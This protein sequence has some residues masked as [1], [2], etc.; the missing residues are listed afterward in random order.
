[1][2]VNEERI[3]Y[4]IE[5]HRLAVWSLNEL[6]MPHNLRGI[7]SDAIGVVE[8]P[9]FSFILARILGRARS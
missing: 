2:M 6:G 1:M 9:H 3:V 5:F 7:A 4:S 8:V